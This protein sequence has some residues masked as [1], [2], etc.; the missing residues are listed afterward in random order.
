VP[1]GYPEVIVDTSPIQYLFQTGLLDL[2]PTLYGRVVVPEAV[3]RELAVGR[4]QGVPLPNPRSYRWMRV[5]SVR[6]PALLSITIDLGLGEWEAIALALQFAGS[7]LVVD[8]ARARRHARLRG[9]RFTG[10]LGGLLRGKEAGHLPALA[11]VLDQ[12]DELGFRLHPAT[13][14]SVLKLAGETI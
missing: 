9:I 14:A 1:E 12:L 11:P 2:L 5:R 6:E 13:R 3:A 10:T 8:D 4:T 7:L